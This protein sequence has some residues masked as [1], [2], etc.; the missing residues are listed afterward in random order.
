MRTGA[1]RACYG[2]ETAG[3]LQGALPPG[4]GT[5]PQPEGTGA[6][7]LTVNPFSP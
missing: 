5:L 4:G 6:P 7:A 3:Q 2:P 1:L